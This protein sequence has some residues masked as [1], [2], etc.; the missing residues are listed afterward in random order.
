M[1]GIQP[2]ANP[3]TTQFYNGHPPVYKYVYFENAMTKG[4]V[5]QW[6]DT[7]AYLGRGVEDSV[8]TSTRVAG[9]VPVTI[10]A[11]G[12]GWLQ[13]GGYCDYITTDTNV[14]APNADTLQGDIYLVAEA[15]TAAPRALGKTA[16]ELNAMCTTLTDTAGFSSAFALNL[17]ADTA[18]VGICI[19]ICR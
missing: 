6:S 5:A 2:L 14:A 19:L 18:A 3:N 1:A 15:N 16:A 17:A 12:W 7:A 10:A 13:S 11:A 8:N 9:V 4:E